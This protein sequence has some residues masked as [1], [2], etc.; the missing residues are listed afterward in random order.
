MDI[1]TIIGVISGTGLVL[2]SILLK[3]SI[4]NFIDV[5]SIFIV[6]GGTFAATLNAF[7]LASVINAIKT[8]FKIFFGHRIDF[9]ATL[10]DMLKVAVL[11]RKEGMLALEK[12]KT[13]DMFLK[14]GLGLV[15]D[16]TKG[17]VLREIMELER[18]I[19]I[20]RHEESQLIL[21]K[22]GE[23]APAWGM[24][25]TLIGLVIMLLSLSDPSSIGPAMAVALL[26]TFYGA[27]WANFILLPAASKLEQRSKREALNTNLIIETLLSI[28]DTENPRVLQERLLGFLP[29]KER[30]SALPGGK[31]KGAQ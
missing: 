28:A 18:D 8:S 23:L 1:A 12:Y 20:E 19:T 10:R 7:P 26:T 6:F 15:A 13:D 22:M 17:Q 31:K 29:P 30:Q 14:K 27:L 3:A 2:A 16:G 21:E 9:V 11:A 5:S 24:I 25:G 4:V